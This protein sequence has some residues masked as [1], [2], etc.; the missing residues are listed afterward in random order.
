MNARLWRAGRRG[1]SIPFA[2]LLAACPLSGEVPPLPVEAAL[3]ELS[4]GLYSAVR[5]SPD[6]TSVAYT[7]CDPRR[8]TTESDPRYQSR[9]RTGVWRFGVGCDVWI[10]D[11]ST[12]QSRNLTG[13][14][15]SNWAPSWS[16]DR[17]TLAFYS[18]RSGS[19]ALWVWSAEGGSLRRVSDL[20]VRPFGSSPM[21]WTL[22]GRSV[23]V[24]VLPAGM[25]LEQAA[26]LEVPP[27][28]PA[29]A[30]SGGATVT[31]YEFRPGARGKNENLESGAWSIAGQTADL[32]IFDV[33][34]GNTR[35]LV[36][37]QKPAGFWLSPDGTRLACLINRGFPSQQSQQQLFDL[38]IVPLAGGAPKTLA[39]RISQ[40]FGTSAGWSPDGKSLAYLSNG[41]ALS[42]LAAKGEC[43]VVSAAGGPSRRGTDTPHPSFGK[44]ETSIPFF[45]SRSRAMFFLGDNAVWR[46]DVADRSAKVWS[47]IEGREIKVLIPGDRTD[48]IL[49]VTRR[50]QTKDEGVYEVSLATGASRKLWEG[51]KSLGRDPAYR[52][53]RRGDVL[54]A[55]AQ[56][57][58]HPED[59][60]RISSDATEPRRLTKV[61]PGFDDFVM[62]TGRLI[63]WLSADGKPLKGALLLPAGYREGTRYP[64][65]VFV[66]NGVPLSDSVHTFGMRGA[67][68]AEDN[69]QLLATRGY[70][71]L[72]P[73][74][75]SD[76]KDQMRD[77]PKNVLPGVNRAIEIGIADPDRLGIMGHSNGGFSTLALVTLTPRF[78]AAVMRAGLGDFVSFYGEMGRDGSNYGLSVAESAFGMGNPW[79]SR[80][81]YLENSPIF[82][83]DRVETPLL[84]VHGSLD[85][86]VAPFLAEEVFVGLRRLGKE[87]AY[88]RYEGEGHSLEGHAN[89]VDYTNRM[90]AWFDEHLKGR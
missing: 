69:F 79:T 63:E 90:I 53:A 59:L 33:G 74:M 15:G 82:H 49:A 73:D 12:G 72:L 85:D 44:D 48:T 51:P 26:N 2:F 32:A 7:I 83:L 10:A 65:V 35:R 46:V 42:Y 88:A 58:G 45:D 40:I 80:D 68:G 62:G 25:T 76:W 21:V 19:A 29:S 60:W 52:I 55:A 20:V 54:V 24:P 75:P 64:L 87:V 9:T 17:R 23:V 86:A 6:G 31:V 39:T 37:G 78:K 11:T 57:A 4:L 84:I 30:Q 81:R 50:E 18:D 5:L 3:S 61:N 70:A 41:D 16:P 28:K 13:G 43:Y 71:V 67:W 34:T 66:Y 38:E 89:L 36:T 77:L 22:D 14:T 1:L 47:K 27:P 56:D 8:V